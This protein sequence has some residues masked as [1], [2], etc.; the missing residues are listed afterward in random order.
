MWVQEG[1]AGGLLWGRM[2]GGGRAGPQPGRAAWLVVGARGQR[3]AQVTGGRRGRGLRPEGS[4]AGGSAWLWIGSGGGGQGLRGRGG[5]LRGETR[6]S[7]ALDLG[8]SSPATP[9]G[10]PATR[11]RERIGP[12]ESASLAHT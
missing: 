5:S 2:R 9:A 4:G 1:E 11:T 3:M 10:C 6:V 8:V 12:R 7:K